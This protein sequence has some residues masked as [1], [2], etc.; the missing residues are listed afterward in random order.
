L[1]PSAAGEGAR[2]KTGLLGTG[3][4]VAELRGAP[5]ELH[6][7]APER[8]AAAGR[9][10]RRATVLLATQE[11]LV[12][13]SSQ[14]LEQVDLRSCAAAGVGVVRRCSGGGAVLVGVEGPVWVDLAVPAGD[15][16]WSTDVGR[17]AWWVGEA[18]SAALEGA[19]V[20]GL[21]VWRGPLQQRPWSERACFAG[22]GAGEVVRAG[23][24]AKLVGISQRRTRAGALF[25]C[26]CLVSWQPAGLVELLALSP[27]ERAVAARELGPLAEG[28]GPGRAGEV[29]DRLLA[30]LP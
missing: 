21:Q 20:R 11:A 18:W 30:L 25:Q 10:E 13:G 23:S 19:G 5:A 8:L 28:V 27:Q 4:Q 22:V 6:A 16:L 26:A 3:W 7:S 24:G 17:A 29:L 1:T 9:G 14:P 12:L 2:P 15:A